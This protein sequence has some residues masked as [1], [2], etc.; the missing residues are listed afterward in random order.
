MG[1][2]SF[3]K[4]SGHDIVIVISWFG[5]LVKYVVFIKRTRGKTD[6]HKARF[7][8]DG[9]PFLSTLAARFD[10]SAGAGSEQIANREIAQSNS[11]LTTFR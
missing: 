7:A 10:G 2:E 1:R 8:P 11:I 5:A 6:Q 3:A 9:Q 4:R